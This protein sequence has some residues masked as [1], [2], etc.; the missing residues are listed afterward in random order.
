M[1][2]FVHVYVSDISLYLILLETAAEKFLLSNFQMVQNYRTPTPVKNPDLSGKKA[3]I[4]KV[5]AKFE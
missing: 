1:C 2:P 4:G 3:K 5:T